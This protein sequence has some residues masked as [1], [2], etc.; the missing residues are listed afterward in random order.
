MKNFAFLLL[1]VMLVAL[2]LTK[3]A[4][5]ATDQINKPALYITVKNDTG[6]S[7]TGATVRLY[8]QIGDTGITMVSDT[9][10]LVVFS[11]LEAVRYYWYAEK[12]C[13]TNLVS[14]TTI[15]YA[16]IPG[17]VFYGYSVLTETGA[18]KIINNSVERYKVSDSTFNITISKDSPY[19]GYRRVKSYLVHS[20]KISSPGVGRDTLI[21]IKCGDTAIIILP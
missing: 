9:N 19:L 17:R 15:N 7:V 4:K 3:C 14:Q 2:F 13:K 11:G 20:E 8:Q 16:L 10:G 6:K 18:L 12:G 1:V 5:P 21:N